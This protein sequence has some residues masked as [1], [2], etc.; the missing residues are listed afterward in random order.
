MSS[1]PGIVVLNPNSGSGDHADAVRRR[2][3]S[4]DREFRVRETEAAG[5]AVAFARE[6]AEDG[7]QLI[8]AAGGDGTVNEVVRGI[9]AAEAFDRVTL[10]VVPVGTGNNFAGNVGVTDVDAAFDVL[11]RG[12]RRRIDVGYAND[13]LFVNSCVAGITAEASAET[14]ADMKGRIG[15]LAYVVNTFRKAADFDGVSLAVNVGDGDGDDDEE[16]PVWSG[17]AE[18]I[19]VGNGRRFTRRGGDQADMEDGLLDV[20]VVESTSG[21]TLAEETLS[22]R[23]LGREAEHAVRMQAPAL[24]VT[25][26]TQDPVSFSLDG[27]IE[28]FRELSVG[29]RPRTLRIAVGDGYRPDPDAED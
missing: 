2:A 28:E 21:F 1:M 13:C 14:S 18:M 4:A 17:D 27:E 15:V 11:E 10:G 29:V 9:A 3:A 19:L 22:E 16:T 23:L 5:D 8:A 12:D 6:A 26:R 20:L 7:A 24:D 25:V